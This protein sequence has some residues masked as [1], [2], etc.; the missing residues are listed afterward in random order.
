MKE[1]YVVASRDV[2]SCLF[3]RNPSVYDPSSSIIYIWQ[4]IVDQDSCDTCAGIPIQ[5]TGTGVKNTGTYR[6]GQT[7]P[8]PSSISKVC[9]SLYGLHISCAVVP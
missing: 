9:S 5:N 3:Y 2:T 8:V 7:V 4:H 6:Y 1:N